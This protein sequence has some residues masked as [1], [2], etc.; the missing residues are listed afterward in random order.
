[1]EGVSF[2]RKKLVIRSNEGLT[3][4]TSASKLLTV[5]NLR[6]QPSRKLPN[7]LIRYRVYSDPNPMSSVAYLPL[8]CSKFYDL[9]PIPILINSTP[10]KTW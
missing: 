1:M 9:N 5:A 6:Y 3:L 10:S 4:E 7:Y 2:E 8:P